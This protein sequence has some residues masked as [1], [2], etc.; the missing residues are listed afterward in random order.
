ME[1]MY[2]GKRFIKHAVSEANA[3][4]ILNCSKAAARVFK[5]TKDVY[6]KKCQNSYD[7]Y[8]AAYR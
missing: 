2:G 3:I 1:G 4:T 5:T 8:G 7:R 6:F